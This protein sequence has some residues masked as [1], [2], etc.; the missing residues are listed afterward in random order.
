MTVVTAF[1]LA[2]LANLEA[3]VENRLQPEAK[4]DSVV[5]MSS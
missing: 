5:S 4:V 3:F 1:S 2:V